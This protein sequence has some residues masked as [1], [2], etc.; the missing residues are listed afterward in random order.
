MN[1]LIL[2][3]RRGTL[4]SFKARLFPLLI[5]GSKMESGVNDDPFSVKTSRHINVAPEVLVSGLPKEV[6]VFRHV[7]PGKSMQPEVNV[8]ALAHLLYRFAA[9]FV[10][11]L[12]G[13]RAAI[14]LNVDI[15]NF[16]NGGPC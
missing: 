3:I 9:R 16:I 12:N 11:G 5:V 2:G 8:V 14:E 6:A 1:A 4:Q 7:N 10:K 13:I 15:K